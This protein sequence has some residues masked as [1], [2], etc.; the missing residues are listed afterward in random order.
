LIKESVNINTKFGDAQIS[1][2][3]ANFFVN[4]GNAKFNDM[5]KLIEHVKSSV[6]LKTGVHLE[7]EIIIL[8]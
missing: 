7:T 3:H 2:K 8:E 6:K 5:K 1:K 4:N